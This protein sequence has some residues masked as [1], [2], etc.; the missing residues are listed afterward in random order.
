MLSWVASKQAPAT[1]QSCGLIAAHASRDVVGKPSGPRYRRA[2]ERSH[3]AASML[4]FLGTRVRRVVGD[5]VYR[6]AFGLQAQ[7]T[8]VSSLES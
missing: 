1:Q 5:M 3:N 7:N 2:S 4:L 6:S 8:P